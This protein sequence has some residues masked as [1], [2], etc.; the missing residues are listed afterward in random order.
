MTPV[1]YLNKLESPGPKE[2]AF[3]VSMQWGQWFM[4]RF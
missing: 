3:Q 2:A 4:R 1:F